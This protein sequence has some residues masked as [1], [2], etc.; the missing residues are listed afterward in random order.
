MSDYLRG[1]LTVPGIALAL[2]ALAAVGL[3]IS[4]VWPTHWAV[5]GPGRKA[6]LRRVFRNVNARGRHV[7]SFRKLVSLG[8]WTLHLTRYRPG[9]VEEDQ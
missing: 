8:P 1:V 3:L 6:D 2:A 5:S 4:R 9:N 7:A